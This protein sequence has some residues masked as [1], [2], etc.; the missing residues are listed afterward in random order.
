MAEPQRI[1]QSYGAPSHSDEITRRHYS[2]FWIRF[3][4]M[5]IDSIL[6]CFFQLSLFSALI[7]LLL[8][9]GGPKTIFIYSAFSALLPILYGIVLECSSLQATIGKFVM[10]IQVTDMNGNRITLLRSTARN[11][12][13]IL[14][15][16]IL[17]IGFLMAAF[18]EKKQALHDRISHCL[19]I[20]ST[21]M[22]MGALVYSFL[23]VSIPFALF[24]FGIG[25]YLFTKKGPE[26]ADYLM[27]VAMRSNPSAVSH[28]PTL[29]EKTLIKDLPTVPEW[30]KQ[31]MSWTQEQYDQI[32]SS[33]KVTFPEGPTQSFGP[34]AIQ[35]SSFFNDS[36]W[37]KVRTVP[38][39]NFQLFR[40]STKI[41][42]AHIWD[43]KNKDIYAKDDDFEKEIFQ[44]VP[45]NE[46]GDRQFLEGIR[47]VRL[48]PG[49]SHNVRKIDG[50]ATLTLPTKISIVRF[51]SIAVGVTKAFPGAELKITDAENSE[52]MISYKGK[53]KKYLGLS[54]YNGEGQ[55]ISS[56]GSSWIESDSKTEIAFKFVF[57]GKPASLELYF[58]SDFVP[59]E[60]PIQLEE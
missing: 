53:I 37:I 30:Q 49:A 47:T 7:A 46:S 21:H 18:G 33:K 24:T 48:L 31:V 2:G 27:S 41:E 42:I 3:A 36:F 26:I 40:E 55:R 59:R 23:V 43:D 12:S 32:L 50:K 51:D 22:N 45:F 17:Y 1:S 9:D 5:V 15:A 4:A 58:A 35:K 56:P 38:I 16:V 13:K 34:V 52:V 54:A 19:V 39:Y 25:W 6:I 44:Y 8:A 28:L 60:Y 20:N 11:L 10:G 14:S 29:P 57:D